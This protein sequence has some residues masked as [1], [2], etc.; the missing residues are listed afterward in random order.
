MSI[1]S[2]AETPT[3][4][5]TR[6]ITNVLY[7]V[8]YATAPGDFTPRVPSI[9]TEGVGSIIRKPENTNGHTL[10]IEDNNLGLG[11][12]TIDGMVITEDN[13]GETILIKNEALAYGQAINVPEVYIAPGDTPT[14]ATPF[15]PNVPGLPGGFPSP[16]PLEAVAAPPAIADY[17]PVS[18]TTGGVWPYNYWQG[19][20]FR[21]DTVVEINE[22]T[23]GIYEIIDIETN[24]DPTVMD[25]ITLTRTEESLGISSGSTFYVKSGTLNGGK[26]F[27]FET[28]DEF[29]N[30]GFSGLRNGIDYDQTGLNIILTGTTA[31]SAS[32]TTLTGTATGSGVA[33]TTL[34]GTGTSFTTELN[35]G[36]VFTLSPDPGGGPF[37][38]TS[39]TNDTTAIF[40]PITTAAIT[41]GANILIA[42]ILNGAGTQFLSQLKIGDTLTIDPDPAPGGPFTVTSIIS[43]TQITVTP[44][45]STT[46]PTGS[47]IR[48]TSGTQSVIAN[49]QILNTS[50]S[51]TQPTDPDNQITSN[52]DIFTFGGTTRDLSIGDKIF[53]SNIGDPGSPTNVFNIS[54]ITSSTVALL[55]TDITS[56]LSVPSQQ[57]YKYIES[58]LILG[59]FTT[60]AADYADGKFI[61]GDTLTIN[62]GANQEEA[63]ISSIISN[64]QLVVQTAPSSDVQVCV[65]ASIIASSDIFINSVIADT[66]DPL[67][68]DNIEVEGTA[69]ICNVVI[70]S[71]NCLA[72]TASLSVLANAGAGTTTLTIGGGVNVIGLSA[73]FMNPFFT[74]TFTSNVQQTFQVTNWVDTGFDTSGAAVVPPND[75]Y[76]GGGIVLTPLEIFSTDSS[77]TISFS[78]SGGSSGTIPVGVYKTSPSNN[79]INIASIVIDSGGS[80]TTTS[81]I[82]DGVSDLILNANGFDIDF[83]AEVITNIADIVLSTATPSI[84]TDGTSTTLTFGPT[85]ATLFDFNNGTIDLGTG[86]LMTDNIS[87][88]SGVIIDFNANSLININSVTMTTLNATTVQNT[89]TLTV[90]STTAGVNI[91]A[92]AGPINLT[93]LGA[94]GSINLV[95]GAADIVLNPGGSG[96]IDMTSD[97][98]DFTSSTIDFA[99][100]TWLNQPQEVCAVTFDGTGAVTI[101]STTPFNVL[102]VVRNGAI[103]GAYIITTTALALSDTTHTISVQA[104]DTGFAAATYSPITASARIT[105]PTTIE[106]FVL[107]PT[108]GSPYGIDVDSIHLTVWRI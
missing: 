65:P 18:N 80:I 12:F 29:F 84:D 57:I 66:A 58:S 7:I 72:G 78:G 43:N 69:E 20:P 13:I 48:I 11:T 98:I 4:V 71:G 95:T 8:N 87:G 15:P 35:V 40:T 45:F 10:I 91:N 70:D 63:I 68:V 104:A 1:P 108:I 24:I 54:S 86:T 31:I 49:Y 44:S 90:Q 37:T 16:N 79:L 101:L 2:Y 59:K 23:F 62:T 93:A 89:G 88:S 30:L 5:N 25:T 82:G 46:V 6:G 83:N 99:S 74:Q 50:I 22:S 92:N 102:S 27:I 81:V 17:D 73:A 53:I 94:T 67:I 76:P 97:T 28:N 42:N 26:Q 38:I 51:N 105:A 39:I 64:T 47:E 85:N 106:V 56:T 77:N 52:I 107:D 32:T 60:F 36:D 100:S 61:I 41:A 75:I 103:I 96:I 21:D 19:H 14:A 3:P 34:A 9:T 33:T 55:D